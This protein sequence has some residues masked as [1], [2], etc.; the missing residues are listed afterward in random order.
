MRNKLPILLALIL[1]VIAAMPWLRSLESQRWGLPTGETT[2]PPPEQA[3]VPA[4]SA[5]AA[6]GV[7]EPEEYVACP[8]IDFPACG[9][10]SASPAEPGPGFEADEWGAWRKWTARPIATRS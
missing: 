7:E 2:V 8:A 9:T 1:M 5:L 4:N 10:S 6:Q 3:V